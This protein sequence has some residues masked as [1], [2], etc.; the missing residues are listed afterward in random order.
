MP[1]DAGI[2]RGAKVLDAVAARARKAKREPASAELPNTLGLICNAKGR[3]LAIEANA[4][5]AIEA[6]PRFAG[7]FYD[8]LRECIRIAANSTKARGWTD[9]DDLAA[10]EWMQRETGMP[11]LRLGVVQNAVRRV[12][13]KRQ[14]DP[15]LEY[16]EALPVWDGTP[17]IESALCDAWGVRD[18]AVSRATSRNFFRALAARGTTPACKLDTIFVYE[19]GQGVL[20]TTALELLGGEFYAEISAPIGSNDFV[21]E[22]RA[23]LIAELG[24]LSALRGREVQQI[25]QALSRRWDRYVEKYERHARDYPRRCVFI[26]TTNDQSY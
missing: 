18:T 26:G 2:E 21:R 10:L 7:L 22:I 8:T 14:R 3:A 11:G 12:A 16:F 6:E 20:K 13:S 15:L 19:G 4:I 25:K 17:R 23:V 24:E 9:D 1:N 5:T